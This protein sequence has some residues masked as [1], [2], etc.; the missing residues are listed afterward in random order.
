MTVATAVERVL[1]TSDYRV[2]STA[3]KLADTRSR[4]LLFLGTLWGSHDGKMIIVPSSHFNMTW[5][6]VIGSISSGNGFGS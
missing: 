5:G 3:L 6:L 2:V 1:P 4:S